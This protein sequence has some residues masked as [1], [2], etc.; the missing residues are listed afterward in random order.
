MNAPRQSG[1][2][3]QPTGWNISRAQLIYLSLFLLCATGCSQD[4]PTGASSA[5]ST[6]AQTGWCNPPQVGDTHCFPDDETYHAFK[7]CSEESSDNVACAERVLGLCVDNPP[8]GNL[9]HC[10]ATRGA[11]LRYEKCVSINRPSPTRNKKCYERRNTCRSGF[12]LVNDQC[13]RQ[14]PTN[15]IPT[16]DGECQPVLPPC[17]QGEGWVRDQTGHCSESPHPI[18][19]QPQFPNARHFQFDYIIREL[20]DDQRNRIRHN[21]LDMKTLI[22][23]PVCRFQATNIDTVGILTMRNRG[24]PDPNGPFSIEIDAQGDSDCASEEVIRY[25]AE[26][27]FMVPGHNG[28]TSLSDEPVGAATTNTRNFIFWFS[29]WPGTG[30]TPVIYQ[31]WNWPA[32]GSLNGP[33]FEATFEFLAQE[34]VRE[35]ESDTYILAFYGSASLEN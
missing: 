15:S 5:P 1:Y 11:Q 8:N 7:I 28:T 16:P 35:G 20:T 10:F 13:T 34:S 22:D 18:P 12:E 14:C 9:K 29:W 33:P 21:V 19:A 31:H 30:P 17:P 3:C 25:W 4:P 26:L 27:Q 32:A 23:R 6:S 24:L 2:T